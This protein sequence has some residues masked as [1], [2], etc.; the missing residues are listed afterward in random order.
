MGWVVSRRY[1]PSRPRSPQKSVKNLIF[2]ANPRGT[3]GRRG[4]SARPRTVSPSTP[5]G[6]ARA[7]RFECAPLIFVFKSH[8]YTRN[9]A[10]KNHGMQ[11]T[12]STPCLHCPCRHGGANFCYPDVLLVPF[13][14]KFHEEPN[15]PCLF[16][17]HVPLA[18]HPTTPFPLFPPSFRLP[19]PRTR[20]LRAPGK[21]KNPLPG[22]A[23]LCVKP[24]AFFALFRR[25]VRG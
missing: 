13:P 14:T 1:T 18:A 15:T 19:S 25:R 7:P 10:F 17:R 6:R 12:E 2:C 11:C 16:H 22:F 5:C 9:S 8:K 21:R 23:S 4:R 20:C 3:D 24:F